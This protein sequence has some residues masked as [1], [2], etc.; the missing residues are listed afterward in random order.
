MSPRWVW[1]VALVA[2]VWTQSPV[3]AQDY[4]ARTVRLIVP[5]PPGGPTDVLIRIYGQML[6]QRWSRPVVVELELAA[7]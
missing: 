1:C 4:P 6:S 3:A 7:R 5:F 2:C